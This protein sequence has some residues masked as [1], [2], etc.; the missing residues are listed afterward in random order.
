MLANSRARLI[1]AAIGLSCL[2]TATAVTQT[3]GARGN[4]P[5][6]LRDNPGAVLALPTYYSTAPGTGMLVFT[7]FA[8]RNTIHLDRQALLKLVNT[9]T[10]TAVWQTT[11]DTSRGVFTD[12][13]YGS[14]EVE[15]SAVGYLS[16][17]KEVKVVQNVGPVQ[18]DIV[19]HRDPAALNLDIVEAALSS[20]ARKQAKRAVSALKS[21]NL[22]EAQRHLDEAY[23]QSPTS[24]ELN[25]L[26]GY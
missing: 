18:I 3:I 2:L 10:Q 25:F 8:E 23:K 12:I 9:T 16:T 7:V 17:N 22:N 21:A 6:D 20:K 15:V 26:L 11:Q 5:V 4:G 19:L 13:P 14:Y 1:A 24:P